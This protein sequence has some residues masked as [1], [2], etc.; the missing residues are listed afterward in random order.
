[1]RTF[2]NKL[3]HT[4][5]AS[6]VLASFA[7]M[8]LASVG[9]FHPAP[10]REMLGWQLA[11]QGTIKPSTQRRLMFYADK[12]RTSLQDLVLE[13]TSAEG[14]A[15]LSN[16]TTNILRTNIERLI[17]AGVKAG[18]SIEEVALF[19]DDNMRDKFSGTV[20]FIVQAADGSLNAMQLFQGVAQSKTT[21]TD[22]SA[23][24][25]YLAMVTAAGTDAQGGEINPTPTAPEK[26]EIVTKQD[27][28]ERDP[29][30]QVYWDRVVINGDR[31]TIN[32]QKGDTLATFANAF[33]GDSLLYRKIYE[34]NKDVISS[35]NLLEVGKTIT[36]PQ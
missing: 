2:T 18:L 7:N 36:I 24:A 23:E 19:F 17:D 15:E 16:N 34:A 30:I 11:Q 35:P 28:I 1:M 14:G 6:I 33:Y 20:P 29:S 21:S 26:P 12:V 10:E 9:I 22:S 13:D 5:V 32:V 27:T 3:H 25:D 31:R 4:L 8:S